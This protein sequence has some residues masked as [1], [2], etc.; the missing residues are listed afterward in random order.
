MGQDIQSLRPKNPNQGT[1][2]NQTHMDGRCSNVTMRF[3][4]DHHRKKLEKRR[5]DGAFAQQFDNLMI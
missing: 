1:S 2:L 3:F 5:T 4:P